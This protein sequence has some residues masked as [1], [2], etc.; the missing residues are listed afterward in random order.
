[1]A[2]LL[3]LQI[4]G[5][6]S[7]GPFE[8][9]I[10]QI[11]FDTPVTLLVGQNGCGKTTILEA[12]KFACTGDLPTGTSRGQGFV[13]DPKI[14]ERTETRGQIRLKLSDVKGDTYTINRA[15]KLQQKANSMSFS[16]MDSAVSLVRATGEKEQ[17]SSRCIDTDKYCA[18]VLQV[19][20]CIFNNVLFCHQENSSWPLDE[21]KKVKEKFDEIFDSKKYNK[22]YEL[23]SKTLKTK[24]D[25]LKLD[26]YEL[27]IKKEKKIDVSRKRKKLEEKKLQCD[28]IKKDT[29]QKTEDLKPH[30]T[31]LHEIE[32][33]E[34]NLGTLQKEL[35]SKETE[36]KGLVQQQQ[37]LIEGISDLF[38]GTNEELQSEISLFE[39]KQRE[40]EVVI[41][42]L[43]DKKTEIEKKENTTNGDIQKLQIKLGQFREE[44]KHYE[45]KLNE[46]S[47]LF[48]KS[49]VCFE[50][51][52]AITWNNPE[53][54]E[55]AIDELKSKLVEVDENLEISIKTKR[56]TEMELQEKI[57]KIR[58][59]LA[60]TKEKVN[61]NIH[62]IRKTDEKILQITNEIEEM[63]VTNNKL[64]EINRKM[65]E[66]TQT[67]DNLQN[68][69]NI[70]ESE[71]EIINT[72]TEIGEMERKLV[73]LEALY[74]VL[75][76]NYIIDEKSSAEEQ[77]VVKKKMESNKI[78]NKHVNNF[79]QLFNGDIPTDNVGKKVQ[80]MLN[81]GEK[82][83]KR[84]NTEVTSLQ[85]QV[86]K[87]ETQIQHQN[88]DIKRYEDELNS[89]KSEMNLV[90]K[91]EEFATV[92]KE[93]FE[94]KE[95]LQKKKGEYSSAKIM[96][97][98]FIEEFEEE[99]A[100][101][102]CSTDFSDKRTLVKGVIEKLRKTIDTIPAKLLET[103]KKLRR[104]EDSFNKL[105]Q[106]KP[107]SENI[108][109]L[110]NMKLPLL[111]E[112]LESSNEELKQLTSRLCKLNADLEIPTKNMDVCR[113][114]IADATL[115]DQYHSDVEVCEEKIRKL[116]TKS[117]MLKH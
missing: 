61:S 39:Q 6:R 16:S 115:L 18:H 49:K 37:M 51:G 117:E 72:N 55:R 103:E 33:L 111:Y 29:N 50:M 8:E 2:T 63:D 109:I 96:Y 24:V 85:K 76:E 101:P 70:K 1:M 100:C 92:L 67:L 48:E 71:S 64:L 15:V 108:E 11:S 113:K 4:S 87:L 54:S 82:E 41:E 106:L 60:T 68:S 57:D 40:K 17:F 32:Q 98:K 12:I 21:S 107:V 91:D 77:T 86:T 31:R 46:Q 73:E 69:F 104:E 27:G 74:K 3:K 43:E 79:K 94:R 13:H 110:S 5:I 42:T 105:Q 34:I 38:E 14:S 66:L 23:L 83:I 90:C 47:S 81:S 78:R 52:D 65:E 22:C 10:Q 53:N 75:Q 112:Q 59:A 116:K 93:T 95:K 84:I 19:S 114:V 26:K 99:K 88:Q 58:E 102:L 36:K 89:K 56:K 20:P 97:E 30:M 28:S 9:H 45:L 44:K 80:I 35:T 7:F 25:K 62:E